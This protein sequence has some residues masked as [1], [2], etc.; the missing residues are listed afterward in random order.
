VFFAIWWA[1]MNFTWFA[2][3]YDTDDTPYRINVF[4]QMTGVLVLAAGI[5]RAFEHLDFTVVTVG[6][7]IMRFGL[8][9]LWLRAARADSTR[10]R[11]ALTYAIGVAL[12]Q[13]GWIALLAIPASWQ[14]VGWL[15]LVPAELAVPALAERTRAT[16]W[17]AHHI[18]ERYGL[19][20]L[21]VLGETVLASSV[22]I[23]SALDL[24]ELSWPLAQAIVGG[25]LILFSLW[26][27][28]FNES[29]GRLLTSSQV[30]FRWGY[31]HYFVFASLAAMGA[32]LALY[33][34]YLSGKAHVSQLL[35]S[36][37]LSSAAALFLFLVLCLHQWPSRRDATLAVAYGLAMVGVLAAGLS[38]SPVL[39]V[40]LLL[41]G[42]VAYQVWR[43]SASSRASRPTRRLPT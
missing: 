4:L 2:S 29:A 41:S 10:R 28:Y 40:G 13:L 11:T 37:P 15:V 24:H 20:T 17:H 32:G 8:V 27:L 26:W 30:A 6:Y 35:A 9:T 22:A 16:P 7:C 3:A 33:M 23:Q 42:L 39:L 1:W 12:C 14:L 25:L 19:L 36:M 34:D 18:A 21:I 31:A 38:R 43:D 5:P